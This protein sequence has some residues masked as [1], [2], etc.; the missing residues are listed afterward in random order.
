MP[1]RLNGPE[2]GEFELRKIAVIGPGIVGMPMAALLARAE[3]KI[4]SAGPAK[5]VV[6]QRNSPTSGW[7]VDSI[8]RGESPIGGVEPDLDQIV[9]ETVKQGLLSATHDP[10]AAADADMVII[11]VQTDKTG[12]AP[13]YGP[14]ESAVDKLCSALKN[15]PEGNMPVIVFESTL[16]PTSMTTVVRDWFSTQ[17]LEEGIDV[18][19]GNSPNRVMPGRLVERVRSSDK[20]VAGLNPVT[21]GII[22]RVYR[23]V[24][25]DGTIY[26]TNSLTAEIEKTLENAFRDVRIAFSAL[27]ARRC[28]EEGLDFFELRDRVNRALGQEDGASSDATEIPS[29]GLLV[30]MV[31]VGGHCLPKDG[32]LLWW[33]ALEGRGLDPGK[34]WILRAR[35]V[36]DGSPGA[37]LHLAE[38]RLGALDGKRVAL[39][40]VAYRADSEDTR[41]SPTLSLAELLSGKGIEVG[42]HDPHVRREDQNL[43]ERGYQDLLSQ[44]LEEALAGAG[45][46]IVC[47]AHEEYL[48][49]DFPKA[50]SRAA[51]LRGILDGANAFPGPALFDMPVPGFGIGRDGKAPTREIVDQVIGEYRRMELEVASEVSALIAYYNDSYAPDVFNEASY[52]EVRELA[53][54]C[55]TGC[56]LPTLPEPGPSP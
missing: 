25:T 13:D 11:C 1:L 55:V 17:G 56:I 9:R 45:L 49:S 40:G 48:R 38:E 31:G 30:P 27:W 26:E 24:V 15:R 23:H 20:L 3:I 43:V 33:R 7:K 32:I 21:A 37:T 4:G 2:V 54:T 44:D 22:G 14:L 50:L 5:V 47:V 19:L 6:I 29:G 42:L 39:L 41:N 34:S 10:E 52:G 46:A 18:L 28:E 53:S 36:N 12:L 16:A 8:N 51:D 35:E